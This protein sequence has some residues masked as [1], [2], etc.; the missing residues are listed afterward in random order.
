ML[1]LSPYCTRE[2]EHRSHTYVCQGNRKLPVAL[3]VCKKVTT[4]ANVKDGLTTSDV[5]CA[6]QE[7]MKDFLAE[8]RLH[9]SLDHSEHLVKF[10][11]MVELEVSLKRPSIPGILT[12]LYAHGSLDSYL[13]SPPPTFGLPDIIQLAHEVLSGL[14]FLHT[15]SKPPVWHCDLKPGNIFIDKHLKAR[16]GDF[17]LAIQTSEPYVDLDGPRGGTLTYQAPEFFAFADIGGRINEKVDIYAFGI[18]LWE[19]LLWNVSTLK[20]WGARTYLFKK[21]HK[22]TRLYSPKTLP[23]RDS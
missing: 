21:V 16:I 9:A 23:N 11:G 14:H 1:Y 7:L 19:M 8:I 12:G 3:A 22:R 6:N 15:D 20:D 17:G 18:T 4:K 2:R 10:I 5:E 13:R